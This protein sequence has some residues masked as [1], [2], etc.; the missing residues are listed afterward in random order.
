MGH[1]DEIGEVYKG[2]PDINEVVGD[3]AYFLVIFKDL[4]D[5]EAS[6][7]VQMDKIT[8]L[9]LVGEALITIGLSMGGTL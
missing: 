8:D 4:T 3:Q 6:I 7:T 9:P 1:I 2:N 5:D